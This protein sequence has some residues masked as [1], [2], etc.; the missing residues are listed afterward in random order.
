[1]QRGATPLRAADAARNCRGQARQSGPLARP[2]P[3]TRRG[4]AE[5]GCGRTQ[6]PGAVPGHARAGR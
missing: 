5:G 4:A 1:M 3:G 2:L 6:L